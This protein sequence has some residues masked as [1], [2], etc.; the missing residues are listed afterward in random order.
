MDSVL[1]SLWSRL[2]L[3]LLYSRNTTT[4][5]MFNDNGPGGASDYMNRGIYGNTCCFRQIEAHKVNKLHYLL[6]AYV[7]ILVAQSSAAQFVTGEENTNIPLPRDPC[8]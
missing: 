8:P 3:C 7:G 1:F 6:L 4:H 2:I 5:S